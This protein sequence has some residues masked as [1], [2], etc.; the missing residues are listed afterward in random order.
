MSKQSLIFFSSFCAFSEYLNFIQMW[1]TLNS[2][3]NNFGKVDRLDLLL[4]SIFFSECVFFLIKG[5]FALVLNL[6]H[7]KTLCL[8]SHKHMSYL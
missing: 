7:E 2:I 5:L 6:L 8:Q 3:G 1:L 4:N